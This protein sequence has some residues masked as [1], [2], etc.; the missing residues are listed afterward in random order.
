M[1]ADLLRPDRLNR[2]VHRLGGFH[3]HQGSPLGDNVLSGLGGNDT[4]IGGRGDDILI[5]GTGHNT[6]TGGGGADTFVIDPSALTDVGLADIII[7]YHQAEGD[8]I[9][10]GDLLTAAFDTGVDAAAV[11]DKVHLATDAQNHT[12][13]VTVDTAGGEVIVATLN[14][15]HNTVSILYGYT[16]QTTVG[17][18]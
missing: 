14:N 15:I 12:T 2:R 10:F 9:D 3:S 13:N 4:L 17:H 16:H 8:R 1:G 5:G 7:D 11:A 18:P 6:L